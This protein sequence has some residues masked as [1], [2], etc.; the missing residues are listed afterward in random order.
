MMNVLHLLN[1]AAHS[2]FGHGVI[3]GV[4]TAAIVDLHAFTSFKDWRDLRT[5]NWSVAS[6]RWFMGAVTGGAAGLGLGMY[7]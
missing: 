3:T 5:Y 2:S 1:V 4:A 6:F 7:L